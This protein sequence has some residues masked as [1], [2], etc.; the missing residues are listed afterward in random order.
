MGVADGFVSEERNVGPVA[1][2]GAIIRSLVQQRVVTNMVLKSDS[3]ALSPALQLP[4]YER[5]FWKTGLLN[6]STPP[7]PRM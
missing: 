6:L 4:S 5:K 1:V 7:C 3:L 2:R